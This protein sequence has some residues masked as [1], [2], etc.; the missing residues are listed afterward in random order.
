MQQFTANGRVSFIPKDAYSKTSS[1][2]SSFKFDFVCDSSL[3]DQEKKTIPSF[4][5][6][7]VY[8]KQAD[9][10]YQ[11]LVKGSPIL[12]TGEI[13]QRPYTDKDGQKKTYQYISPAQFKG[14]TFLENQEARQKRL[15]AVN[16]SQLT[17]YSGDFP[18][19]PFPMEIEEPF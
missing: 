2:T 3:L 17:S 18:E 14:I 7:Q 4:F 13:I 19:P 9:K 11:N 15:A 1:G 12:L 10:M 6:V 5:H 16:S 8:G